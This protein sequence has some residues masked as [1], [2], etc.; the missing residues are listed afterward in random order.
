MT[1]NGYEPSAAFD[2]FDSIVKTGQAVG[3]RVVGDKDEFTRADA[4]TAAQAVGYTT[5]LPSKQLWLTLEYLHDWMTGDENVDN[6]MQAV[7][8][9]FVTGKPKE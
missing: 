7:W 8:R 1:H 3:A 2:M 9:T 4:K 6:P 5:K